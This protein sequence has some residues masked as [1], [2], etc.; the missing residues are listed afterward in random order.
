MDE[1][2]VGVVYP[3]IHIDGVT[4]KGLCVWIEVFRRY[5][6]GWLPQ[7]LISKLPLLYVEV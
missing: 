1:A 7:G 3:T 2:S 5:V 6:V 4:N